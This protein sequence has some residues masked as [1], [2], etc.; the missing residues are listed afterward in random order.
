MDEQKQR[1]YARHV[2]DVLAH[3][4]K[5]MELLTNLDVDSA[6]LDVQVRYVLLAL[7]ELPMEFYLLG[8]HRM[9]KEHPRACRTKA[10]VEWVSTHQLLFNL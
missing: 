2:D 8:L 4:K 10:F 7:E 9:A 3:Y 5:M 6:K 1:Q